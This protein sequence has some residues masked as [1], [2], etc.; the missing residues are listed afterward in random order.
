MRTK[1][2][3]AAAAMMAAGLASSLAQSN[4]YSLN[5]VGYVNRVIPGPGK[6]SMLANP[7]N[8]T[9]NTLGGLLTGSLPVGAQVLVFN[10]AT[11]DYD[12]YTRVAFG[13]GWSPPAGSAVD[14]SPGKGVL[15]LTPGTG[16]DV[17]NTFV[18]EVLQ[19]SLSHAIG[20]GYTF[21][22]NKVPDTGTVTALGLTPVLSTGNQIGQ[23]NVAIQDFDVSTRTGFPPFWS[24]PNGVPTINVA[25][26]FYISS[27]SAPTNWV[28]NFTV[29]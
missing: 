15:I 22:G 11:V 9:S 19:G 3:L 12:T 26:G 20:T 16:G 28:R 27:S 10:S 8:S 29:Q 17:T 24:G 2:L 5:V 7:L 21:L 4:V 23:M 18:G 1:T 13:T 14:L 6:Y 25:D